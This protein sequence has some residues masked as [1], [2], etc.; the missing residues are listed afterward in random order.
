VCRNTKRYVKDEM[1]LPPQTKAL[2]S[3][4]FTAV[5]EINYQHIFEQMLDDCGLTPEGTPIRQNWVL[6]ERVTDKMKKWLGIPTNNVMST[7]RIV[8]LR[9]ACSHPA[10]GAW[11]SGVKEM[12]TMDEVL[13]KMFEET[14]TAIN[15]DERELFISRIKRGQIY[16]HKKDHVKALEQWEYVLEDIVQRVKIR[17][18]DVLDI[19]SLANSD[20]E[21][22]SSVVSDDES[23]EDERQAKKLQ[24]LRTKRANELRDLLDLQHRAT[25]MMASAHFQLK[26]ETEET[27]LY[28]EAETLRREVLPKF[29]VY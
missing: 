15:R 10:V 2:L 11:R 7:K 6:N 19:K 20:A 3:V 4:D 21:S 22:E 27:R 14:S 17:Q 28:D 1:A 13:D 23:N 5:E 29:N 25:F 8:R 18:T 16:D 24:Y 26:N 12:R 9:Q